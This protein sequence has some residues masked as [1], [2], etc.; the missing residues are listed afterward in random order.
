M[1]RLAAGF[2]VAVALL[3]SSVAPGAVS[4]EVPRPTIEGPITGGRG[5]PFVAATT[6]DLSEVGYVQEEY[7]ISGTARAF[8]KAGPLAANGKWMV[9]PGAPA[10]HKTPTS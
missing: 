2:V 3:S 6:F 1:S 7:F 5:T 8:T 10:P 4:A 9:T